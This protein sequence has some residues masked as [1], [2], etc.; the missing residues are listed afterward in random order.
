MLDR[1][2]ASLRVIR[3]VTVAL[4]NLDLLLMSEQPPTDDELIIA[5]GDISASA[6][7]LMCDLTTQL[8]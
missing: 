2:K 1:R 4:G 7:G 8:R 3:D 6:E 5:L